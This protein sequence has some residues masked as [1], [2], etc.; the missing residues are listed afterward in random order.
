MFDKR[1]SKMKEFSEDECML[2]VRGIV[3]EEKVRKNIA[4]LFSTQTG[5]QRQDVGENGE[6]TERDMARERAI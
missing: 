2:E 4:E 1:I 3:G 5:A 6:K